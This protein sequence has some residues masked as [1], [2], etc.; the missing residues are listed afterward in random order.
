ME[1]N[2]PHI[3]KRPRRVSVISQINP[4]GII[5]P[6]IFDASIHLNFIFEMFRLLCREQL[7]KER[8]IHVATLEGLLPSSFFI[9]STLF[10]N[11]NIL[12]TKQNSPKEGEFSFFDFACRS[13]YSIRDVHVPTG[14]MTHKAKCQ[15]DGR[16][17]SELSHVSPREHQSVCGP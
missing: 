9:V 3:F 5:T 16:T 8:R 13:P 4:I 14:I 7:C 10:Q 17:T 2:R 6:Y 11:R 1:H 15:T 12:V